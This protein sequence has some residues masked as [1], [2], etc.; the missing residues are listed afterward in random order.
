MKESRWKILSGSALKWMAAAIMFI[1]H[2]G[3]SVIEQFIAGSYGFPFPEQSALDMQFWYKADLILRCI[4][5]TA[6]P[7]F[8]F[9]LVE[10]AVHTRNARRYA[11]RLAAFAAISELP[12]DLALTNHA[13]SWQMQNVFFTLLLGFLCVQAFLRYTEQSWQ[14]WLSVL[15][16]CALAEFLHTD[17]GAVGV[18][19]IV[20]MYLL[21]GHFW[22][23]SIISYLYLS[24]AMGMEIFSLPAFL[25]TG[26]YNGKKGR[27]P[28]WFFY[29]FYPAHLLALWAVG[30][31]L[32]PVLC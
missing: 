27:Q 29:V 21:R 28:R 4:G 24:L 11:L 6:F 17:Y 10:G 15:A 26:L 20:M 31:Y 19:L 30:R 3:A 1:D 8:C 16:A 2:I 14:G 25:L 13:F 9:L 7:L 22:Q 12:F 23:M 18:L 32:L 5:R